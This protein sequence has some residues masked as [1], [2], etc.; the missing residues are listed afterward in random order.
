MRRLGAAAPVRERPVGEVRAMHYLSRVRPSPRPA[1]VRDVTDPPCNSAAGRA[2]LAGKLRSA[3]LPPPAPL[4]FFRETAGAVVC[5]SCTGSVEAVH[6]TPVAAS[7]VVETAAE[8]RAALSASGTMPTRHLDGVTR[9][10]E[11]HL[12]ATRRAYPCIFAGHDEGAYIFLEGFLRWCHGRYRDYEDIFQESCRRLIETMRCAPADAQRQVG[13]FRRFMRRRAADAFRRGG[14]RARVSIP[15]CGW[16]DVVGQRIFLRTKGED[17]GVLK[18]TVREVRDFRRL[19][20]AGRPACDG[21]VMLE[22]RPGEEAAAGGRLE[23][24]IR[25]IDR[26]WRYPAP[27]DLETADDLRAA[28]GPMSP[29]PVPKAQRIRELGDLAREV[30]RQAGL[31][32]PDAPGAAAIRHAAEYLLAMLGSESGSERAG[33]TQ[34]DWADH[35]GV[36]EATAHRRV[37]GAGMLLIAATEARI[38]AGADEEV[39]AATLRWALSPHDRGAVQ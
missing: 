30:R 21:I 16:P 15:S 26:A 9:E 7:V 12:F 3:G 34:R 18:G 27:T 19:E 35:W 6:C 14:Y 8:H 38:A 1:G 23:V 11:A 2:A 31:D 36:S 32:R 22:A 37:A 39:V 25:E 4:G 29:D 28:S 10:V 17:T 33:W 5:P 20:Q 24:R 13:D